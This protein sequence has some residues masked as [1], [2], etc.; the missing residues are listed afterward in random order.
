MQHPHPRPPPLEPSFSSSHSSAPL[1]FLLCFVW[2]VFPFCHFFLHV[3]R[4]PGLAP[5]CFWRGSVSL[6][7]SFSFPSHESVA[8][9]PCLIPMRWR[10]SSWRLLLGVCSS[11]FRCH[12]LF[13][14]SVLTRTHARP[15]SALSLSVWADCVLKGKNSVSLGL[16]HCVP[17]SAGACRSPKESFALFF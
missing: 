5:F 4:L 16:G 12:L 7:V 14:W 2:H 15:V 11:A 9:T 3:T 17:G 13:L 8:A 1:S 6:S 10:H